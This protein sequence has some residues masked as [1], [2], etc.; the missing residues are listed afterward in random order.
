MESIAE[1]KGKLKEAEIADLPALMA[2]YA[3]DGRSGVVAAIASAQKRIDA[4]EKEVARIETMKRF[5]KEY[6]MYSY[7]CGIDEVGRGPLAGPVVTGAVILPKDCK[8]L[9]L[10]DSKKL[11]EKK[12]EELYSVITKEA[13]AYALGFNTPERIDEINILQAT[14]EAMRE[15]VSK[16]SPQPDLL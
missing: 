12:R 5:E 4:H 13:V 11:S 3:E 7:I 10:N 6:D 1:I 14:L 16:L 8:I 9:Y 2:G 15:A